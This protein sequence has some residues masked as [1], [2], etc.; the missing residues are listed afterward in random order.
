[1]RRRI[2]A[3][4]VSAALAGGLLLA[5]AP[6]QAAPAEAAPAAVAQA[7]IKVNIPELQ[8]QAAKLRREAQRL[9]SQGHFREANVVD[10]RAAAIEAQVRRYLDCERSVHC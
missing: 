5:A 9:R 6:A 1:M 8:A 10:A 2:S 7:A 4:T 3:L